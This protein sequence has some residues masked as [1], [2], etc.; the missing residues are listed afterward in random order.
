M[1]VN[2]SGGDAALAGEGLALFGE[3]ARGGLNWGSLV[4][5]MKKMSFFFFFSISQ[6]GRGGTNVIPREKLEDFFY[7]EQKKSNCLKCTHNCHGLFFPHIAN[8]N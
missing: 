6:S 1:Q 2:T 4:E 8:N 7:C 3:G 5:F